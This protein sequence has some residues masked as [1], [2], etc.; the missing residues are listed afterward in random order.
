MGDMHI[1]TN[2]TPSDE[3]IGDICN[4]LQHQNRINS[5]YAI[6]GSLNESKCNYYTKKRLN[7]YKTEMCR[8][9][10]EAGCCKYG[11]RCQF[12]HDE[13]E[14][15]DIE[16]HPRYKTEVCKTFWE[17]GT[18]P[19]GKRCCFIHEKNN[20]ATNNN[21]TSCIPRNFYTKNITLFKS[22]SENVNN[23]NIC[24]KN[25]IETLKS[26]CKTDLI[27]FKKTNLE[28][29]AWLRLL[30]IKYSKTKNQKLI[31]HNQANNLPNV[32]KN[33]IK[34][35]GRESNIFSS[36]DCAV[37]DINKC[38]KIDFEDSIL[39]KITVSDIEID[40]LKKSEKLTDDKESDNTCKYLNL[41]PFYYSNEALLWMP[42]NLNFVYIA[43]GNRKKHRFAKQ[44]KAPGEPISPI[45]T[46]D[47]MD[48]VIKKLGI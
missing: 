7:L 20:D 35:I 10:E 36:Y 19:Y 34:T 12:A 9:F 38:T 30:F 1:Y 22:L 29:N 23:N 28:D 16:R 39:S 4:T 47:M 33:D 41:K 43:K 42:K 8:S 2:K 48:F 37:P 32:K 14:I 5:T 13:Q 46:E 6:Y 17:I 18:C 44:P 21:N 24:F 27:D 15:R 45:C 31:F 26:S 3:T 25:H 40:S 11:D